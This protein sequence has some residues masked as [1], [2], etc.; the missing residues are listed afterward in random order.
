MRKL[1]ILFACL[2]GSPL[3]SQLLTADQVRVLKGHKWSVT[4]LDINMKGNILLSGGWDNTM[5]LWDLTND[6][7]LSQFGDHSDMIWDV[8]FSHDE[9]NVASASWD[10]SIN[11]WDIE[12]GALLYKLRQEPKFKIVR[13][14]PFHEERVAQNMVNTIAFSPDDK[15]LASG[16]SDGMIRIWDLESGKLRETIDIHD[17]ASV[18]S[19][20]FDQSGDRLISSSDR[21][22]IYNLKTGSI[23]KMLDGHHGQLI[24]SLDMD[25]S[26]HLLIS[27]DIA[28]RDP[29]II[30]WDLE[31]GEMIREYKG[32]IKVIRELAFSNNDQIIAS[33]GEDN[34][35]KIWSV[36]T[37]DQIITF[38]D[39]DNKELNTVCFSRDDQMI[40]YGS[41]DKTI[42]FRE[43]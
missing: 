12:S 40:I 21:I 14:E 30:L 19:L 42:K 5:I 10:A 18:N 20:L 11:I 17:S 8:A 43:L 38:S 15:F 41:Q 35:I 1:I 31:T 39:N 13:T 23:E 6:T 33:V 16:S 3:Y 28:T 27:G 22:M 4:A 9:N 37:G 34:L 7:I 26:G 32:H 2:S 25:H 24:G 36:Q 29:L